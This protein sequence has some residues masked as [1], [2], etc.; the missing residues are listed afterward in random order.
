MRI[1][2]LPFYL[3]IVVFLGAC[4]SFW[5]YGEPDYPRPFEGRVSEPV[6]NSNVYIKLQGNTRKP[7]VVLV[8]GLGDNASSVWTKAIENLEK[9]YFLVTLDLPGFGKSSKSNQL[10]SPENYAR[11]IHYLAQTYIKKPFH[12]VG[13][14]MGGAISLR[15]AATYPDDVQTLTLIGAAGILHRLAYSKYL[16]ALGLSP[17][18]DYLNFRKNDMTATTGLLLNTLDNY[19]K[20]DLGMVLQSEFLRASIL[21]GK[22][23]IISAL[24]LVVDDFSGLT[25]KVEAPTRLIWGKSDDV[26]PVRIG[27]AL[28]ALIENSSLHIIPDAGHMPMLQN[29]DEFYRLLEQSLNS[30]LPTPQP[31]PR[32]GNKQKFAHCENRRYVT[33]KGVIDTLIINNCKDV[34]IQNALLKNLVIKNSRV[35]LENVDI[36]STK[37]ALDAQRSTIEITAG[38]I[39]GQTAIKTKNSR[40]DIAGTTLIGKDQVISSSYSSTNNAVF[41]LV[42]ISNSNGKKAILHGPYNLSTDKDLFD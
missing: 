1:K 10:Y 31:L 35:Y 16:T 24:A 30:R 29:T 15:Y 36:K 26:A 5:P 4:S 17:L 40:L 7:V 37:I 34:Y 12:L 23:S 33:Y 41:S 11:L 3:I 20:F 38:I 42:P 32:T 9:K 39:E 28:N 18:S 6:F 27:H 22:P 19:I 14:S 25:A 8:H 21:L 2:R 13:H